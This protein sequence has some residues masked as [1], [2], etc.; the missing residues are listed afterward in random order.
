MAFR[1]EIDTGTPI[2]VAD[3]QVTLTI[4]GRQ[5]SVPKGTSVMAAAALLRRRSRNS[6]PP[7]VWRRSAPAGSAWSRSRA[8]RERP[9]PARRPP[10]AAWLSARRPTRLAKLRRGVME[11]YIS[12][13]PLDCLT[14]SANGDCELQT[15]AGVVGLRDVRYGY[16]GANHLEGAEGRVQPLFHLRSLQVH[17]LLALRAR[18]RGGAGHVRADH[19]RARL[20][21]ARSRRAAS[22]SC[23]RNASPAAPACRPARPRRSTRRASSSYGKA[24]REVATTCAYCG[25]GCS[26]KAEVKGDD[27]R[28]HDPRQGWARPTRAIPASR[29]ASPTATPPTRTAS[30]SR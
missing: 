25:V 19:P 30:P 13:H 17:R 1:S 28:P 15:Q 8:A 27:R 11:L 7:T 14:C 3:E 18:L 20:R 2:R 23:R 6:A 16:N 29:A 26:F 24:E 10:K 12:D 4:D 5:V 22:T 21:L 9:P